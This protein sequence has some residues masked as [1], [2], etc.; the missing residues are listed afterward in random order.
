[1]E[2]CDISTGDWRTV[3][4]KKEKEALTKGKSYEYIARFTSVQTKSEP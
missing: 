2:F 4:G 3:A 1:M